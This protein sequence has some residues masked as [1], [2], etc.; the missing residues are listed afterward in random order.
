MKKGGGSRALG[1][2]SGRKTP[3]EESA[4]GEAEAE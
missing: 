2:K 3:R 1:L 4:S